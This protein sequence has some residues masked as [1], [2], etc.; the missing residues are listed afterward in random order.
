ML[1]IKHSLFVDL[2][3]FIRTIVYK[4]WL[5]KNKY[6]YNLFF[7]FKFWFYDYKFLSKRLIT[8]LNDYKFIKSLDKDY[9]IFLSPIGVY[10]GY[11][12]PNKV[13]VNIQRQ[14]REIAKTVIHEIIH[15]MYET[16]VIRLNLTQDEKEEL[17]DNKYKEFVENDI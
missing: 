15:L 4:R 1:H 8:V 13:Y 12:L 14:D 9:Y 17:V 7:P 5:D 6:Y 3:Q 10:G 2:F 16:E 11:D